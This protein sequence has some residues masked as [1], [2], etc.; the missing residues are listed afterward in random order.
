MPLNPLKGTIT[1]V[2]FK[3][4]TIYAD[5]ISFNLNGNTKEKLLEFLSETG[6]TTPNKLADYL[7]ISPQALFRHIKTLINLK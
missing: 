1:I 3:Y 7:N 2:I 5:N 6:E 4:R